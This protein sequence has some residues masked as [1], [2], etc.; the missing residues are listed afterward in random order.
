MEK[1]SLT[2]M[3]ALASQFFILKKVAG[4][5]ITAFHIIYVLKKDKFS[6]SL[7]LTLNVYMVRLFHKEQGKIL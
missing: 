7:E 6:V 5:L 2:G 3:S 4:F 1:L